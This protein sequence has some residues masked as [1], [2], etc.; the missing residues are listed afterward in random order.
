VRVLQKPEVAKRC[1]KDVVKREK[2]YEKVIS[3][4]KVAEQLLM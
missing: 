3:T 4:E 2:G 1:L